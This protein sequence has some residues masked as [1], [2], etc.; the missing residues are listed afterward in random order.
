MTKLV[1]LCRTFLIFSISLVAMK[2]S[3]LKN[4]APLKERSIQEYLNEDPNAF[5]D[6]WVGARLRLLNLSNLG[7]NNLDGLYNI[8]GIQEVERLLLDENPLHC[9]KKEQIRGLAHLT[10]LYFRKCQLQKIE[11]LAITDL[12]SLVLLS[13]EE[14]SLTTIHPK[15]FNKLPNL[16]RL[17]IDNNPNLETI[18]PETIAK[19]S[20]LQILMMRDTKI[21]EEQKNIFLKRLKRTDKTICI[22]VDSK[23]H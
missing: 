7:I 21:T 5:K 16:S 15:A 2:P 3:P 14:N 13:L 22:M 11:E 1:I 20:S 23:S 18:D 12:Q 8:P 10:T 9:I 17:D 4:A 19:L 6:K